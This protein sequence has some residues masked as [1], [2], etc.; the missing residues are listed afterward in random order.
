[1]KKIILL[2]PIFFSLFFISCSSGSEGLQESKLEEKKELRI[3]SLN[4]TITEVLCE[5]GLCDQL[6]AT[7]ITSNYPEAVAAHFCRRSF[8]SASKLCALARWRM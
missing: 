4:G 5:I 2:S 3:V 1:M 7:D 6:V 8:G